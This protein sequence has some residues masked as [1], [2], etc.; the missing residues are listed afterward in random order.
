MNPL[1]EEYLAGPAVLEKAVAGMSA[2]QLDARPIP[3]KWS[4]RE[5]VCHLSDCEI[6]YAQRIQRVLAED[7]PALA[8]AD[9]DLL[10]RNLCYDKRDVAEELAL[11]RA[12][13]TSLGRILKQQP[14]AAFE[15]VGIHSKDGPLTLTVLLQRVTRHIP[16]HVQFVNEKRRA[17]ESK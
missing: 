7:K 5:V 6:L 15:R 11:V 16:H 4:T 9:P 13:R 2:A 1:I 3:G 8:N 14:A 17:L 10:L 12:V